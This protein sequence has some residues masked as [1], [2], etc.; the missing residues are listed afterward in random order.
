[1]RKLLHGVWV[2]EIRSEDG[3]TATVSDHGAHVLS[4]TPAGGEEALYMSEQSAYGGNAAIRGGVPIIF[5]QFGE[6]GHGKRHGFARTTGWRIEFSG[7]E[8]GRAVARYALNEE[9]VPGNAWTHRFALR[10]EVA[11]QGDELRMTLSV[12]NPSQETWTFNA[13][14][15]SYWRVGD[16]EQVRVTGLRNLA[17]VDQTAQ[18]VRKTQ[19]D[20][21]LGIEGEID[22][23]YGGVPGRI[24]LSDGQRVFFLDQPGF[25]D[26]VV[27]NPGGGKAASLSDLTPGGYRSFL[28]IEAGAV[29]QPIVLTPGQEWEGS[30]T[31]RVQT[32]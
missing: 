7:I 14:L 15:H 16:I 11:V 19:Y 20:D 17:Y 24:E 29:L 28:C 26:A 13:A 30:Q 5:P 3:A 32:I 12:A 9:D 25:P 1:M 8:S 18:G 10:Y 6:R 23:I 27:W 21:A 31:V 22:R 2:T 4:W